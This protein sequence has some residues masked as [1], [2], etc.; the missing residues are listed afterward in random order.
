VCVAERAGVD[1]E[2]DW[3]LAATVNGAEDDALAA[4]AARTARTSRLAA[5]DEKGCGLF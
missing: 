2:R 3:I 1:L 5:S 4:E